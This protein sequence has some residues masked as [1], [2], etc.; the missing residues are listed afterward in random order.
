M[1]V[2]LY[3]LGGLLLGFHVFFEGLNLLGNV[4]DLR[5]QNQYRSKGP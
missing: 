2:T 5:K 4:R 3:S 1:V